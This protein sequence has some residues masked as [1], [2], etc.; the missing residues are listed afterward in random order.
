MGEGDL[1]APAP[2]YGQGAAER[3]KPFLPPSLGGLGLGS[4]GHR[5][6]RVG[7]EG[8]QHARCFFAPVACSGRTNSNPLWPIRARRRKA[9]KASARQTAS[10]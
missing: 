6:L 9:D 10:R 5:A 8:E 1:A 7:R 4:R 3:E 2:V